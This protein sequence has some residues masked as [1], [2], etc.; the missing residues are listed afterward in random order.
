MQK[1]RERREKGSLKGKQNKD[2]SPK[3]GRYK[4]VESGKNVK[5]RSIGDEGLKGVL[6]PR[7]GSKEEVERIEEWNLEE[8]INMDSMGIEEPRFL[9]QSMPSYIQK[10]KRMIKTNKQEGAGGG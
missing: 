8:D 4:G 1:K 9:S 6:L 3:D 5:N 10:N 2:V 7:E